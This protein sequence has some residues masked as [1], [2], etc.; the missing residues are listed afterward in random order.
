MD[1]ALALQRSL[2]AAL[3][4]DA[5]CAALVAGR[6]YDQPPQDATR[7]FLGIGTIVQRP[8]RSDCGTAATLTFSIEASSRP[9]TSG[10]VEATQCGNAVQ[11]ALDG[12]ALAVD[13][14][15]VVQLH[16]ITTTVEREADGK[17]YSA[18][19]AFSVILDA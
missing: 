6:V 3:K 10:R 14:L 7:P 1:Y 9:I 19:V 2:V 13:G 15:T 5:G 11:A 18:I 17:S 8:L 4:A 16:W 12:A